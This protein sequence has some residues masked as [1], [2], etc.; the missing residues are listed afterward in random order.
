MNLF[1]IGHSVE[2]HILYKGTETVKPGGLYYSAAGMLNI[3]DEEDEITLLTSIDENN[4]NLYRNIY[5]R[6]NISF[7]VIG[8]ETVPKV[9]LN[10]YDHK[11]R[12]ERYDNLGGNIDLPAGLPSAPDGILINMI[13]GLDITLQQLAELRRTYGCP[14]YMDV[15]SLTRGTDESLNR[16]QHLIQNFSQWAENLDIVQVNDI[17]VFSLYDLP[18]ELEIARKVL[19]G[20]PRILIVTKGNKGAKA[21]FIRK[22]EVVSVYYSAVKTKA[23][24]LVGLGDIFGAAFF[25]YYIKSGDVTSSL[26]IANKAAG[27]AASYHNT[28][29]FVKLKHDVFS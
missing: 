6:V 26:A 20:G 9:Y 22:D 14:V 16:P 8:R 29:E 24:N 11:E 2:D 27:T 28:D 12:E 5:D 3:K 21:Y 15:H 17:E 25:H 10:I 4:Y 13:T 23:V 19:S 18:S 1:L 7:C